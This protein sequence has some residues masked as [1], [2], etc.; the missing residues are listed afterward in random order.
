RRPSAQPRRSALERDPGAA[1]IEV[2]PLASL[3]GSIPG[4]AL[5]FAAEIPLTGRLSALYPGRESSVGQISE[6][7]CASCGPRS[8]RPRGGGSSAPAFLIDFLRVIARRDEAS[9]IAGDCRAG[10]AGGR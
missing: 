7:A 3:S 2:R 1:T 10:R 5:P 8:P 9:G 6:G 4:P